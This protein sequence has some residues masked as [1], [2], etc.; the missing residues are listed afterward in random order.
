MKKVYSY[1]KLLRPHHYIKNILVLLPLIF[2]NNLLNLNKLSSTL[3]GFISFCLISS[4]VYIIND[5]RDIE[6]DKNHPVKKNRPIASGEISIYK[7]IVISVILFCL[8]IFCTSI[9]CFENRQ[10]LLMPLVYLMLYL[11]L[12]IAYSFGLKNK[13]IIDIVILVSG[14]LIRLLYGG[15]IISI[16]ISGWLYLT[17]ISISFYLGLGK[18]RN[19][20][21]RHGKNETRNVLKYYTKDFLD[22]NM[23]ISLTLA[24]CFYALW[25]M[26]YENK[27]MLWSVPIVMIMAMKYSYDIECTE[28]EGDPVNILLKDKFIVLL[29]LL[30]TI[31]MF[32]IIYVI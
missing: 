13:P 21:V 3:L 12:N 26:N 1:I 27:L 17:I 32:Y 5:I 28:T 22:K 31:I 10:I 25:A 15:A 4:T 7:A 30:Y 9:A 19:E 24:I 8:S 6:K 14:F 20:L 11:I 2:S 29:G 16:D 23:N 18:R